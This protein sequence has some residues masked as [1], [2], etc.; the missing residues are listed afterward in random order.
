MS[1]LVLGIGNTI[2]SDDGVGS[3]VVQRL[4]DE[5]SFPTGVSVLE[6]GTLGLDLLPHLE[7][8]SRL[9]IVDALETG[10]LPGTIVRLSG[11][12]IPSAFRTRLSPH[13]V[14]LQDLL[15]VAAFQGFAPEEMVLWGIQPASIEPG[16]ELTEAVALQVEMLV[17]NVLAELR[18]WGMA[19]EPF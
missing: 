14:G 5:F 13:Q 19:A 11:E 9:L 12:E 17:E 4:Q 1:V 18:R 16:T 7:G 3:R 2:M 15:A 8:I 6:G 10:K